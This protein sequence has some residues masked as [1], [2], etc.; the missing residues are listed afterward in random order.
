MHF[1]PKCP[2]Y[3]VIH[4][5]IT[6]VLFGAVKLMCYYDTINT[7]FCNNWTHLLIPLC[8]LLH[9][10][11]IT[12][13]T[14][15]SLWQLVVHFYLR[16]CGFPYLCLGRTCKIKVLWHFVL[17]YW[18]N[19]SWYF[20]IVKALWPIKM[21][22]TTCPK[23]PTRLKSSETPRNENLGPSIVPDI[24]HHSDILYFSFGP[25]VDTCTFCFYSLMKHYKHRQVLWQSQAVTFMVLAYKHT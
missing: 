17:C 8:S 19:S 9:I 20:G 10:T 3:L 2:S 23:H 7:G 14:A 11:E 6:P 22:V 13:N 4:H 5:V 21:L 12:V 16:A 1:C 24:D 15:V 25:N 18:V